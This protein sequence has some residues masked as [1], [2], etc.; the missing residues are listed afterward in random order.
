MS[1]AENET[2]RAVLAGEYVLGLL[3]DSAARAVETR[4]ASDPELAREIAAWRDK[5][6]PLADLAPPVPPSDLLWRRIEADLPASAA[7]AAAPRAGP[8]AW[9]AVAV[10]SLALAAG[11]AAFVWRGT[12]LAPQP[13][14]A[15]AIALLSAPGTVNAT[16]RAQV[17]SAGTITVVPLSQVAGSAGHHLGFWAWPKGRPAPVLLGTLPP[18]G[19]QLAFP[20]AV[21]DGTP[22]MVT[23]EPDG[24]GGAAPGPTLFIGLLVATG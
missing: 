20:F 5:L 13:P 17:T 15:K 10:A 21:E 14:W 2:E 7:A 8:G 1:G 11:L 6:D 9:R 3:D 23:S 16:L 18:E 12:A 4:A 19:G 24:A 22:V